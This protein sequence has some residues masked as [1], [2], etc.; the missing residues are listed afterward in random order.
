MPYA[1]DHVNIPNNNTILEQAKRMT[2]HVTAEAIVPPSISDAKYCATIKRTRIRR[3][4]YFPF[5]LFVSC[6]FT[7][8]IR[9]KKKHRIH[10]SEELW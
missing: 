2:I 4:F 7:S 10:F 9:R 1:S 6:L 3:V 8:F 5:E